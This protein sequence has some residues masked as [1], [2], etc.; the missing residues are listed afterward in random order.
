[1]PT[2]FYK[3]GFR[4]FIYSNEEDRAHVHIEK[5]AGNAK[6]WLRPRIECEYSYEFSRNEIRF[7]EETINEEY[8]SLIKKWNDYNKK[9]DN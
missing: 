8:N 9:K 6:Y 4:F 7:I 3:N 2:F 1:V 5:G